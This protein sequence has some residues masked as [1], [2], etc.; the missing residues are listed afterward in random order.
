M[1]SVVQLV[2]GIS[3]WWFMLNCSYS[4]YIFF[5]FSFLMW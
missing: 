5:S 2:E 3:L 4:P 1:N